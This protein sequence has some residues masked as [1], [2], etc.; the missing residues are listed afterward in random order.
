MLGR[1]H[2]FSEGTKL[3][4]LQRPDAV[5]IGTHVTSDIEV[6]EFYDATLIMSLNGFLG[7]ATW[8]VTVRHADVAGGT[9]EDIFTATQL[10]PPDGLKDYELKLNL[11][12]PKIKPFL[13]VEIVVAG[14]SVDGAVYLLL[15]APRNGKVTQDADFLEL[16]GT[17]AAGIQPDFS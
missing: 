6:R 8:D 7:G 2:E 11:R 5:A 9:Y 14:N 13:E 4:T 12:N 16:A 17:W 10:S 1:L 3:V 15:S